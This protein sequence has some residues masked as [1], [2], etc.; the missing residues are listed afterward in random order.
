M[1]KDDRDQLKALTVAQEHALEV[2]ER[3][4][5]RQEAADAAGV[6]RETVSRWDNHHP[7][8]IAERNQ[9]RLDRRRAFADEVRAIDDLALANVR[10]AVEEGDTAAS[11]V[12]LRHI[13]PRIA[14]EEPIG[15]TTAE[16]VIAAKARVRAA[17]VLDDF[18]NMRLADQTADSFGVPSPDRQAIPATIQRELRALFE[19]PDET[20]GNA[21]WGDS[22]VAKA[23]RHWTQT[24]RRCDEM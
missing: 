3:G 14:A 24:V 9:R 6:S 2:L 10:K 19:H 5:T 13:S 20:D 7:G 21:P 8:F 23:D 11:L 17:E 18:I 15:P 4:R 1:S 22:D 12:W 16:E